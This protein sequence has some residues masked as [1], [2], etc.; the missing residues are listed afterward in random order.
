[1]CGTLVGGSFVKHLPKY[2]QPRW[3]YLAVG[4]EAWP[5]ASV[6]RDD[7]QRALW[8]SA[9]NLIGDAGS[10]RLDLS[11]LRFRFETGRGEALVRT[12]RGAVEPTRAVLACLETVGGDPVG[13]QVRGVSGTVRACEEKYMG[14]ARE[15]P[16]ER[17]V[18]FDNAD[19]SALVWNDRVDV[20]TGDAFAGATTI[21]C[22]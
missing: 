13:I 3:R 16:E 5:D 10:A 9:Q 1:M 17:D 22:H 15:K 18:V 4:I 2:L 7:F 21:D 8:Y 12:R 11:V 6:G 20:Q 14:H 19:R